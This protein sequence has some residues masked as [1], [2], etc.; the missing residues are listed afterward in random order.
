MFKFNVG[1]QV[2]IQVF[3]KVTIGKVFMRTLSED[4]TRSSIVY[5]I[6]YSMGIGAGTSE[7]EFGEDFLVGTQL[8]EIG[9]E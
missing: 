5:T 7:V 6:K 2:K 1:E 8:M 3:N 4:A 9:Y